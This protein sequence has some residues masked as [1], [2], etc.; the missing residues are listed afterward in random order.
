[1]VV[2]AA[3]LSKPQ[4]THAATVGKT[5]DQWGHEVQ[6]ACRAEDKDQLRFLARTMPDLCT[7]E[8]ERAEQCLYEIGN[9]LSPPR[10]ND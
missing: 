8:I 9:R 1:M 6:D 3:I 2:A 5:C 10:A 7:A 4:L